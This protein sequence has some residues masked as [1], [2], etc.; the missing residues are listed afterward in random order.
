[1]LLIKPAPIYLVSVIHS[2]R[3]N[4]CPSLVLPPLQNSP[5]SD[6]LLSL[7]KAV[8]ALL[9]QDGGLKCP[10]DEEDGG[11]QKRR[12]DIVQN[13][14]QRCRKRGQRGCYELSGWQEIHNLSGW[15]SIGSNDQGHHGGV[16]AAGGGR[17]EVL[18]TCGGQT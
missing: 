6:A 18:C 14:R 12:H 10:L 11:T 9:A 15:D 3:T 16:A 5:T 7:E 13:G 2:P 4:P 17:R 1:M 8:L